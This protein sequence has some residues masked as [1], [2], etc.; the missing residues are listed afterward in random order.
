MLP[1]HLLLARLRAAVERVASLF[2][3]FNRL[4]PLCRT[5]KYQYTFHASQ[6]YFIGKIT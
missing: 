4:A 2:Q 1:S 3:G 6:V 5:A